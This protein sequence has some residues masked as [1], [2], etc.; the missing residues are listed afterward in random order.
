[1]FV[2]CIG[3][4]GVLAVIPY[5]AYQT[6]KARNAENTAWLLDAAEHDL[7]AMGL[8]MPENWIIENDTDLLDVTLSGGQVNIFKNFITNPKELSCYY[9]FMVDPFSD[10]LRN[11]PNN[12]YICQIGM[13]NFTNPNTVP[14]LLRTRMTGQ[15]DLVY[16][17]HSD[18]RT[19]FSGQDNKILSSGQYTWFFM[20]QPTPV[21]STATPIVLASVAQTADVD[22]LGCYNRV[23]G[24]EY[25][26]SITARPTPPSH[27]LYYGDSISVEIPDHYD[28]KDT[29]YVFLSWQNGTLPPEGK[30]YKVI[31]A[32][33]SAGSM[34]HVFLKP[35]KSTA[36]SYN[37][38]PIVS[39]LVN[40]QILI[41]PGLMY[42]K[43][44]EDV[45]IY[46]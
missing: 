45:E 44:V 40:F 36:N 38:P 25:V 32:T 43:M 41:I 11:D 3:L 4:L 2:I 33:E 31:N 1:M 10:T 30:W 23:P 35:G 19:D 22:I 20:F 12:Q 28:L 18:K 46:P 27:T 24:T 5:G 16:T 26:I 7:Q 21:Q 14:Q 8:A 9:F 15:D 13:D 29:K 42:H 17:L 34:R 6:A 39:N 37:Y